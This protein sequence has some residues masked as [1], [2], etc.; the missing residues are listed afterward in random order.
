MYVDE[1]CCVSAG[2]GD[3]HD[4]VRISCEGTPPQ[5]HEGGAADEPE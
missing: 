3:G 2:P 1:D 4:V 5:A